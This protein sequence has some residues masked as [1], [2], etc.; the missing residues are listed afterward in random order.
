MKGEHRMKNYIVPEIEEV[1]FATEA[2]ADQGG[3]TGDYS[4]GGSGSDL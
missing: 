1:K 3:G 2:I 4:A